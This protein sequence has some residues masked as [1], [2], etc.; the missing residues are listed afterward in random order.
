MTAAV[1]A[2]TVPTS[3]AVAGVEPLS[4][5][6]DTTVAPVMSG[7]SC[8]GKPAT[9]APTVADVLG[10]AEGLGEAVRADWEAET[11]GDGWA[12]PDGVWLH[13]AR[14]SAPTAAS[15]AR[16]AGFKYPIAVTKTFLLVLLAEPASSLASMQCAPDK[17][18]PP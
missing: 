11:D 5:L 2:V 15:A 3:A 16:P 7:S 14:T 17:P 4:K 12:C 1:G 8:C 10:D 9:T 18:V 13:P 6:L